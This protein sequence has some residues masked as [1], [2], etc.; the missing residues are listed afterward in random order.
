MWRESEKCTVLLTENRNQCYLY[1]SPEMNRASAG[2][3]E[4]KSE[5]EWRGLAGLRRFAQSLGRGP[6][7]FISIGRNP[8]KSPDSQ[9]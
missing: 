7:F 8:L 2:A 6:I 9:K 4:E 1:Q 5:A 3:C